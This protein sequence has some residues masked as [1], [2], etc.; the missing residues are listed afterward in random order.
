MAEALER[1]GM[2]PMKEYI[3]RRQDTI[4]YYIANQPILSVW[5]QLIYI[6]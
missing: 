6:F 5:G 1:A 3:R 2:W 4:V